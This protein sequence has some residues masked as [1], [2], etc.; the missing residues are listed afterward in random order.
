MPNPRAGRGVAYGPGVTGK[1]RF[2]VR[3]LHVAETYVPL[4]KAKKLG[5]VKLDLVL[6]DVAYSPSMSATANPDSSS[7][8]PSAPGLTYRSCRQ[9]HRPL[10]TL[11]GRRRL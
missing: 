2:R 3:V 5:A 9:Q 11:A 10:R 1:Y 8:L 7:R 6:R 4:P